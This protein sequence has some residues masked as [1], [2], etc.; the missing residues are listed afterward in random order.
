MELI[1][2]K[3]E[4]SILEK[5]KKELLNQIHDLM[6]K[7]NSLNQEILALRYS[8]K[9]TN[10][11]QI[12]NNSVI[13]D[14]NKTISSLKSKIN[15]I[16]KEKSY[17]EKKNNEL[18]IVMNTYKNE[19]Q[20][21]IKDINNKNNNNNMIEIKVSNKN[22]N[23]SEKEQKNYKKIIQ[24]LTE[25]N[26][27]NNKKIIQLQKENEILNQ[28]IN[29]ANQIK[30]DYIEKYTQ[31][32]KELNDEKDI[33]I[34]NEQKIKILERKLEDCQIGEYDEPKTKTYKINNINKVNEIE[35]EKLSKKYHSP[36]YLKNTSTFST[37]TTTNKIIYIN[38]LED[39]EIS[40][41]NFTIIKQFKLADNL[42]WYLLKRL[43]KNNSGGKEEASPTSKTGSKHQS[44]RYK[45]IKLNSKSNNNIYNDDSYSDFIWKPNKNEKD[46]INFNTDII[47]NDI[48]DNCTNQK[49]ITE[50]ESNIKELEEKLE[51]KENDCNRINLNYA[52]LFNRS[53]MPELPYDKLLENNEKLREENK[54]LNKKI[55]NLKINQNF[56][57]FSFIEDDLEGSRFI[58]DGC[59]EE[60][61]NELDKNRNNINILKYFR[62]HEDDKDNSKKDNKIIKE[63]NNN[64]KND[65]KYL[66]FKKD[67]T[68]NKNNN[69]VK[70]EDNKTKINKMNQNQIINKEY[71]NYFVNNI[72]SPN[73]YNNNR[74]SNTE[75]KEENNNIIFTNTNSIENNNKNNIN[76]NIDNKDIG[77]KTG[78]YRRTYNKNTKTTDM[79]IDNKIINDNKDANNNEYV[80]NNYEMQDNVNNKFLSSVKTIKIE[81]D[82][83]NKIIEP[84]MVTLQEDVN[85]NN[86]LYRGIRF[87]KKKQNNV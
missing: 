21:Q 4:N 35:M 16:L 23:A 43:K 13:T 1:R 76:I 79:H 34:F 62:S 25:Q 64:Y 10:Y 38:N 86:K 33:N 29:E 81:E 5:K 80:K 27:N 8:N 55:E 63:I 30:D 32:N 84:K 59:F 17:L 44:R 74:K 22:I 47:E 51:K 58:D 2:L 19:K 11:S 39:M 60:I 83:N 57:G 20:L 66:V 37:N 70:T 82:N 36:Y 42:K 73:R 85:S 75:I 56:I 40:P 87:Y 18:K 48:N 3:K 50:L 52:K 45:Y 53:K 46:F 65:K 61:L 78:R 24:D 69:V 41:D 72:K 26:N 12:S 68:K 49:K 71:C 31:I 67:S 77:I 14:L 7:N 6:T 54:K 15:I 9:E 28:K